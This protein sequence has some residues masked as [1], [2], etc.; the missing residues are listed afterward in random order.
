[1]EGFLKGFIKFYLDKFLFNISLIHSTVNTTFRSD[2]NI[3]V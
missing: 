2:K 3:F 1:M